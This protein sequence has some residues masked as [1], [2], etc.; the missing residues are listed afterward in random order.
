MAGAPVPV[1]EP[2]PALHVWI[3][4]LR[5][6]IA[7]WARRSVARR[8]AVT[9]VE[10][11]SAAEAATVA[12]KA[13]TV[14]AESATVAAEPATIIVAVARAAL[15]HHCRWSFLERVYAHG[16][17]SNDIFIDRH[18]PFHL[19]DRGRRR[20]DVEQGIVGLAIFLDAEGQ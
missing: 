8:P 13:A 5:G 17:E 7:R 3:R 12:A 10:P 9:P 15:P 6:F 4:R 19:G 11:A 2:L 1:A 16:H 14:A 18:L 20:I